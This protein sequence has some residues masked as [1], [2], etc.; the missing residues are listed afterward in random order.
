MFDQH[1]DA[2]IEQ[3]LK[4]RSGILSENLRVRQIAKNILIF[5]SWTGFMEKLL[6][7]MT[8]IFQYSPTR[9]SKKLVSPLQ[10]IDPLDIYLNN[11]PRTQGNSTQRTEQYNDPAK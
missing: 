5:F 6:P 10:T 7:E 1:S 4:Q 8:P 9:F 2:I 11:V 3:F